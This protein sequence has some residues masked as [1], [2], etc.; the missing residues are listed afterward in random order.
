MPTHRSVGSIRMKSQPGWSFPVA[1]NRPVAAPLVF[2]G[3]LHHPGADGIEDDVAQDLVE[4][5]AVLDQ[6]ALEPALEEMAN[7]V[8]SLVEAL[9]V[10]PLSHCMP[11]ESVGSGV[12][13]TKW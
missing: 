8:V 2:L 13:M 4:V 11:R 9:G 10:L 3:T 5:L 7:P 1:G 12:S 6:K